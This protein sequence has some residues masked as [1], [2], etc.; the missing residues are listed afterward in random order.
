MTIQ[1]QELLARLKNAEDNFVER[2]PLGVNAAEIRRSVVAFANSVRTGSIGVLFVGVHEQPRVRDGE[3]DS[4]CGVPRLHVPYRSLPFLVT[5]R[6][7][8]H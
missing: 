3:S 7:N 2:K 1:P 4:V 8:A 5:L 6:S